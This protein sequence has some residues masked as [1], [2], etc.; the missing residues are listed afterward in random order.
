MLAMAEAAALASTVGALTL[1]S[2][3]R[4]LVGRCGGHVVRA[5]ADAATRAGGLQRELHFA[6][7]RSKPLLSRRENY[8]NAKGICGAPSRC[9]SVLLL[10]YCFDFSHTDEYLSELDSLWS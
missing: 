5:L 10:L 7:L 2:V 6:H 1:G 4:R 8:G 3:G 9:A